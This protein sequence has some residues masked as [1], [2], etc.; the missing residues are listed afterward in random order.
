[1]QCGMCVKH[2]AGS[3]ISNDDMDFV[4]FKR[5]EEALPHLRALVLNGIGEPLLH[6]DLAKMIDFAK[7]RM[8]GGWIGFQ[9]NGQLVEENQMMGLIDKG[10]GKVCISADDTDGGTNGLLHRHIHQSPFAAVSKARVRSGAKSFKLGAEIVLLKDNLPR[11]PQLVRQL[12]EEGCDFVIG[13]HLLSYT[14]DNSGQ[15]LF[16]TNTREARDFYSIQKAESMAQGVDLASLTAK[17]WIA[18]RKDQEHRLQNRYRQMLQQARNQD[19]WL[20]VNRLEEFDLS[21]TSLAREQFGLAREEAEKYGIELDLPPLSASVER[22][23]RFITDK[24]MFI[25]QRGN[26]TPCHALWHDYTVYMNGEPKVV[27]QLGFGNIA[28][29][30]PLEIWQGGNS[31]AFRDSASQYDYPFCH[32]C[33]LGPCPD[34]SGDQTPF[35]NDCFGVTVPCGHCLWCLD[36]VRCL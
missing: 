36:A 22:N 31:T 18:P 2:V 8:S 27:K 32:S 29:E 14:G 10:L 9:T 12:G 1:M 17:T 24:A 20:H 11:L 4:L 19:L 5:I 33:S 23:C 28:E 3:T 34:I 25:D 7:Q 6:P 26:V 21:L 30:S 35:V 15:N 16:D 13:T